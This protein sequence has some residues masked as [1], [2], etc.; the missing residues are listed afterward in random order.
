MPRSLALNAAQDRHFASLKERRIIKRRLGA[1]R[2]AQGRHFRERKA[3][4]VS[5]TTTNV[6][7]ATRHVKCVNRRPHSV[8]S[9]SLMYHDIADVPRP[10][11]ATVAGDRQKN[12]IP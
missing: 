3:T 5:V 9:A 4:I 11:I 6:R 7:F 8:G 1:N 10:S 2:R 12:E